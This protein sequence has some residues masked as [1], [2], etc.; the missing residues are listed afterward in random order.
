MQ[1][2]FKEMLA[3]L[4]ETVI[5]GMTRRNNPSQE[6]IVVGECPLVMLVTPELRA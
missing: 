5:F 1:K 4:P 2:S 3:M 6:E